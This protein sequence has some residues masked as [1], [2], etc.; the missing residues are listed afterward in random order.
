MPSVCSKLQNAQSGPVQF[1]LK[2]EKTFTA[3][4]VLEQFARR[5]IFAR[6]A[7]VDQARE[8]LRYLRK[9]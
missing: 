4:E 3:T 1:D 7:M 8:C 9:T 5:E 2:V 6:R